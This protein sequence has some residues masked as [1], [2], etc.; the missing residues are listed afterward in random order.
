M[1]DV[2]TFEVVVE[3]HN[4]RSTVESIADTASEAM[5]DGLRAYSRIKDHSVG[6]ATIRHNDSSYSVVGIVEGRNDPDT[7]IFVDEADREGILNAG[8]IEVRIQR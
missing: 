6:R 7:E 2:P 1:S 4:R 5:L 8:G 3:R